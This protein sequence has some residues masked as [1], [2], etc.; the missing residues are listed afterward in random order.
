MSTPDLLFDFK[1]CKSITKTLNLFSIFS[2]IG[3]TG[4]FSRKIFLNSLVPP[5]SSGKLSIKQYLN[6][7]ELKNAVKK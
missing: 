6:K 4:I 3:R 5:I 7:L 2:L 1:Y